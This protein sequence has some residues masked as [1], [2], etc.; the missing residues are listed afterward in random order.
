MGN[1]WLI[2]GLAL[3]ALAAAVWMSGATLL[4]YAGNVD[5]SPGGRQGGDLV[6]LSG[7]VTVPAG[8]RIDGSLLVLCC[9]V[10]SDGAV[11]G[12]LYLTTGNL[13]LGPSASVGG[14]VGTTAANVMVDPR[15]TVQGEGV[16]PGF[17]LTL[18]RALGLAP[19]LGLAG[20]AAVAVGLWR[21]RARGAAP[22]PGAA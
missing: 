17:W 11:A 20:V 1:R 4:V 21:R 12:N 6:L 14:E 19:A 3:L 10:D 18:L 15:A 16:W 13:R 22:A 5:L 2:A 8:A 9:N 7:N